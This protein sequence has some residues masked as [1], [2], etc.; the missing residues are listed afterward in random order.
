[1]L[2]DARR[3]NDTSLFYYRARIK[4]NIDIYIYFKFLKPTDIKYLIINIDKY[5]FKY[6]FLN[7]MVRRSKDDNLQYISKK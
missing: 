4:K 3:K 1:M 6:L 5:T 2:F 7:S